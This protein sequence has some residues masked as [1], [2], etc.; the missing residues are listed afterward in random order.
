MLSGDIE[1][2]QWH[3]IGKLNMVLGAVGLDGNKMTQVWNIARHFYLV[4]S[5]ACGEIHTQQN[6][7]RCVLQ[8][9]Y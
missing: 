3:E 7:F 4:F 8:N 9:F 1:R 6:V 5:Q 2:D